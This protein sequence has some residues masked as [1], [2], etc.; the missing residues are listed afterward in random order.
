MSHLVVFDTNVLV[1]YLLPT[2]K[3]TAVKQAIGTMVDKIAVPIYSDDIMEEYEDVLYRPKFS[4]SHMAVQKVLGFIRCNGFHINPVS[5]PVQFTDASDRC[6]YDAAL[7]SGAWL[8]TGNKRHFPNEPFIVTPAEY[9][10]RLA[11]TDG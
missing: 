1:S 3:L 11:Q 2:K 7:S 6:F 10:A 5:V 8:V 9:L 4:F